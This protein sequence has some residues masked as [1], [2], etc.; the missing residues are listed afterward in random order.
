MDSHE[1]KRVARGVRE[2]A[3][4]TRRTTAARSRIRIHPFQDTGGFAKVD[5]HRRL[6]CGFP[7]VIFG[8]GKTAEQIEAIL[9]TLLAHEQ[10]GLVTRVDPR[11]RR[12]PRGGVPRGRA[13]RRR[14]DV[15]GRGPGRRRAR[16]WAGS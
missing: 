16:S 14:P 9:R 12:A 10:G 5:L 6:R 13:Q 1:L 3:G 4:S 7:E 8:Q 11:G 2:R 15:P